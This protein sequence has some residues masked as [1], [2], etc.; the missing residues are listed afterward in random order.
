MKRL[1]QNQLGHFCSYC[2]PKTT[3]AVYRTDG[4][5]GFKPYCCDNQS[6]IDKLKHSETDS[7]RYTEADYQTWLTV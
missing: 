5:L 1:K 3:R 2:P 6:C 4:W 7:G